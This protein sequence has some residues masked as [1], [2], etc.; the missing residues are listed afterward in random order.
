MCIGYNNICNNMRSSFDHD[1]LCI[2]ITDKLVENLF[3][4]FKLNLF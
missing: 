4:E 3:Y 2:C 1:L